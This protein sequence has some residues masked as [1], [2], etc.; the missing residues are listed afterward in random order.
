MEYQAYVNFVYQFVLIF[1][2]ICAY[3]VRL[4]V[5]LCFFAKA[6]YIM[7][8]IL[9]ALV[10]V[11]LKAFGA[12]G[13]LVNRLP[14]NVSD[15]LAQLVL[16]RTLDKHSLLLPAHSTHLMDCTFITRMLYKDRY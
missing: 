7:H 15:Q 16:I 5:L 1:F 14:F 4:S 13:T 9:L 10:I 6:K 11:D 12:D 8:E 2:V 3:Y